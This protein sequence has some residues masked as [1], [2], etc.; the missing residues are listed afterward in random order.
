MGDIK[1]MLIQLVKQE[2]KPA[3]G[4][5]EPIAVAFAAA[6]ARKYLKSEIKSI[7]VKVS[8]NIFKNGKS[9]KV[10]GTEESGLDLAAAL[11]VITGNPDDGFNV[12]KN[13]DST[14]V[15]LAH[16]MLHQN[17]ISVEPIPGCG[18]VYVEMF[19]EGNDDRVRTILSGGHTHIQRVEVNGAIVFEDRL[20]DAATKCEDILK[21]LTLKDLR[22]IAE[23][24]DFDDI[25]FVL[26]GVEM[27]KSAAE[28]GLKK[29]K[30]LAVGAGLLKLQ[31]EGRLCCD[32]S[33]KARILTAAGADF[34]MGGGNCP[35]MT[36]GGSGN[37]GLGIILPIAVIAEQIKSTEERLARAIFFAHTINL[38]VKEYTGKLSALCGCAI[39][40]GIGASAGIAW[41]LGGDD[42]KIAGSIKNML[43]NLTGMICDGA[44]ESCALKLSTSAGEA[45]LAAYLACNDVIVPE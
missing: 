3:I 8:L 10:P 45:V 34:R 44:K 6:T 39:A 41:I 22:E 12:F 23:A 31:K 16:K 37:Q 19:L 28:M 36:S 20:Q 30:G 21:A 11:G 18:E 15:E 2:V 24:V 29:Q 40:A 14:A 42:V 38:F 7:K 26:E 25:R 33:L 1:Q 43:A 27:N 13:V 17:M 9:V 5:T 4:C 35:I 32:P